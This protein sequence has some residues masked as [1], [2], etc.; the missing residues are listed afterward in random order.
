M[1]CSDVIIWR[2]QVRNSY[3]HHRHSVIVM[4]LSQ[5]QLV[6]VQW[7]FLEFNVLEDYSVLY[8]AYS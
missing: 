6:I 5:M 3:F 4:V 1:K 8:G 2:Y 7:N